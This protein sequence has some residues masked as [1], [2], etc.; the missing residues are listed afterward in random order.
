MS[1]F[2]V[3]NKTAD[4]NY[5]YQIA[6]GQRAGETTWNKWGYNADVDL[7]ATETVWSVGGLFARL[8]SASGM[9]VVSSST[10]D[11]VGG[12]GAQSII[13]YSV[14]A[15]NVA[16]LN[17]VALNGTTPVVVPTGTMTFLGINRG[18]I[19]LAGSGGVNAGDITMTATTGGST[20]A[21][22][23]TG[24]G[25]TQHAFFFIQDGHT[26]LLDWLHL[27]IV[28]PAGQN[29]V[30]TI[31]GWV[32]SLVSGAKY[33]VL[34]LIIDTSVQ[35]IVELRPSQPFVIG[36]KSLFELQA[37]T[38]KNDTHVSAR[39]SLIEVLNS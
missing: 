23:P 20:Q 21:V 15:N 11:A 35:N 19:Y 10:D 33:E 25:S 4:N 38:D 13:V 22:I 12:T 26:A 31:K 32:T 27:N 37:S 36:E 39:F 18:S 8:T 30:V 34:R 17:V 29:P 14:D 24:E 1:I 3:N 2:G 28:K 16:Q 9:T 7:A 5:H 6:L